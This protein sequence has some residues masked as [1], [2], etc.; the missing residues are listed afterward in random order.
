[1]KAKSHQLGL[2]FGVIFLVG[3]SSQPTQTKTMPTEKITVSQ[4]GDSTL[5]CPELETKLSS[6]ESEAVAMIKMKQDRSKTSFVASSVSDVAI[7]LLS[8]SASANNHLSRAT[9][10]D[11]TQP[12]KERIEGLSQRHHHLLLIAKQKSCAFVPET[13]ARIAKL[14]EGKK[15][16]SQ[17]YR[18]RVGQ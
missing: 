10:E 17:T 18:Q 16:P 3:C 1:M 2:L 14:K 13:E 11:F 15:E 12:E 4:E 8:G 5:A 7:A 6:V 9:L